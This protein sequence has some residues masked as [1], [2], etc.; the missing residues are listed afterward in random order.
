MKT[1]KLTA[2]ALT[3]SLVST[4]CFDSSDTGAQPPDD[5]ELAL[6]DEDT[7]DEVDSIEAAELETEPADSDRPC[8]GGA[9][10]DDE[11]LREL[12]CA[13]QWAQVDLLSAAGDFDTSWGSRIAAATMLYGDDR[14]G[15]FAELEA[16]LAEI[17]A[18]L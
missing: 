18:A 5:V 15:A 14:D 13:V 17:E 2:L 7:A 12:L 11:Q 8:E 3:L 6:V 1:T 10:P 16:V 4:A 9:F